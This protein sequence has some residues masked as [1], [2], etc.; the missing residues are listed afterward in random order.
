[1]VSIG[2]GG[3][4]LISIGVGGVSLISIGVCSVGLVSIRVCGVGLISRDDWCSYVGLSCNWS[5][6]LAGIIFLQPYISLG[7]LNASSQGRVIQLRAVNASGDVEIRS[8]LRARDISGIGVW[9]GANNVARSN[10]V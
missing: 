6:D 3:V 9:A 1:M 2:V 8:F 10:W 7:A 5:Q 4:G